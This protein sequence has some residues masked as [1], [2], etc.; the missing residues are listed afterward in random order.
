VPSS[1]KDIGISQK[2]PYRRQPSGQVSGALTL[3][4]AASNKVADEALALLV[5]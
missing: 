4:Q 1:H 3:R 2:L 5:K